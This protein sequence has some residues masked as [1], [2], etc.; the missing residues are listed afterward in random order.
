MSKVSSTATLVLAFF[1]LRLFGQGLSGHTGIT[2]VSRIDAKYRGRGVSLS[3]LGYST[4][5]IIMPFTAILLISQLGWRHTWSVYAV[6]QILLVA[7]I[8]QALLCKVNIT[9]K[10]SVIN[11]ADAN[12]WNR[13]QV[14]KDKRFWRI[15][16]ALFSPPIISTALFFHQESL[17]TIKGY[18]LSQ[19][20]IGIAAYSIA[21]V[22]MH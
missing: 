1:M 19:W 17:A 9:G 10:A 12:A 5:E 8:A 14:M 21:A 6:V 4:A 7:T 2:T 11:L 22:T 15:A 3:G 16:P 13:T 18:E 20:A